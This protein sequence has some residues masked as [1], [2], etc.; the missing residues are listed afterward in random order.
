MTGGGDTRF[1]NGWGAVLAVLASLA[2]AVPVYVAVNLGLASVHLSVS[3]G[4]QLVIGIG[5]LLPAVW[6]L[7]LNRPRLMAMRIGEGGWRDF[8]ACVLTGAIGMALFGVALT[9]GAGW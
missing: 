7:N 4:L 9:I 2:I 6:V 5:L 3:R 1:L 8:G